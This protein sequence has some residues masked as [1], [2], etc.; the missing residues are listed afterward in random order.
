MSD[1]ICWH[2]QRKFVM[3]T[4]ANETRFGNRRIEYMIDDDID[5]LIERIHREQSIDIDNEIR[6]ELFSSYKYSLL[7]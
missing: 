1:G 2:E 7:P 3:Q 6:Y 4:L 5:Q